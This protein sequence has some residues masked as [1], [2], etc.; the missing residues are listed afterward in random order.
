[1]TADKPVDAGSETTGCDPDRAW[2]EAAAA[3]DQQAYGELVHRYEG[4]I[5]NLVRA[6]IG[7]DPDAE[8]TAQEIF[9][10][11]F[12]GLGRF[13][14]DSTF[15]TW[16][17]AIAANVIRTHLRRRARWPLA[18]RGRPDA[19]REESGAR[20]LE[21]ESGDESAEAVLVRRDAIDRA[22]ATLTPDLRLVVTLRDVD[23][24]DYR[25]IAAALG[26]PIGTVE[27][28]LFRAR[29]RL[30]PLLGPLLGK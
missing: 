6:S 30:R 4:R 2:V 5:F 27:S 12:R 21:P 19:E 14:Q 17:Y 9:V 16:L 29:Q 3:G 20:D 22:L 15:K 24:L 18:P 25:Q 7:R 26:V 10:R 11:A 28:R 13:R 23:G 1:M 8:D